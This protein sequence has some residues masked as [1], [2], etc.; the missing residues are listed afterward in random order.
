MRNCQRVGKAA[1]SLLLSVLPLCASAAPPVAVDPGPVVRPRPNPDAAPE[2]AAQSLSEAQRL[3]LTP[4]YARPGRHSLTFTPSQTLARH[5]AKS[6]RSSRAKCAWNGVPFPGDAVGWAQ[7]ER[8]GTPC[9]AFVMQLAVDFDLKALRALPGIRVESARLTYSE[10]EYPDLASGKC[11]L[12][13]PGPDGVPYT[14][15]VC[16]Q[17]GS[18]APAHKPDGCTLLRV[19]NVDWMKRPPSGVVP[20]SST[21]GP[22]P[23]VKRSN[24]EWDVTALVAGRLSGG[25]SVPN[26]PY[27]Y[28][29]GFLIA[30]NGQPINRLNAQDNSVCISRISDVRLSITY[31][32][33]PNGQPVVN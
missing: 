17:G 14:A 29:Y 18:G 15:E 22:T 16:W 30:S 26:T 24:T 8:E 20:E 33:P 5:S 27:Q 3:L 6:F 12:M 4:K 10:V 21:V 19:P 13:I 25:L 7:A 31:T 9:A 1:S 32:V 11:A 28:G 2:G 23:V